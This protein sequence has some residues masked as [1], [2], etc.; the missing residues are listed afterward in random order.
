[1]RPADRSE[2]VVVEPPA[3]ALDL[4]ASFVAACVGEAAPA[5]TGED[6]RAALAIV[7]AAYEAADERRSVAVDHR[8]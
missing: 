3:G 6:G 5:V 1:V 7:A 4:Y 2:K 8:P